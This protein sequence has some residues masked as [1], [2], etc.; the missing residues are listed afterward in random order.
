MIDLQTG[1]L[2]GRQVAP[3]GAYICYGILSCYKQ[4]APN[5]AHIFALVQTCSLNQNIS[6][7]SRTIEPAR[8]TEDNPLFPPFLRGNLKNPP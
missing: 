1:L 4:V 2:V 5:G 3:N 6:V 7:Q 8:M